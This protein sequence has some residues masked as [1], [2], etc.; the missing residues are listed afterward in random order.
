[1]Q[2]PRPSTPVRR[3]TAAAVA[4]VIL[5][6]GACTGE[7]AVPIDQITTTTPPSGAHLLEPSDQMRE[8]AEQQCVDDPDLA[9]GEISA[10]DPLNPD[11]ILAVVTV[12]CDEVR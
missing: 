3:V 7:E 6:L 5:V 12:D 1:M 2:R 8:L 4:M 9:V 10:V 11:E